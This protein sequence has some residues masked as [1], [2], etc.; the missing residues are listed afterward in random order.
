MNE[1]S[2]PSNYLDLSEWICGWNGLVWC[3]GWRK[4]GVGK[5]R[6]GKRKMWEMSGEWH[7]PCKVK[8]ECQGQGECLIS[9]TST[10]SLFKKNNSHESSGPKHDQ[11][12]TFLTY[13]QVLERRVRIWKSKGE[14]GGWKVI[15]GC[16]GRKGAKKYFWETEKRVSENGRELSDGEVDFGER[17]DAGIVWKKGNVTYQMVVKMAA[18]KWNC[19]ECFPLSWPWRCGCINV[20]VETTGSDGVVSGGVGWYRNLMDDGGR[21]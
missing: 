19:G 15:F 18:E 4:K 2:F 5:S 9:V 14:K 20:A 7:N 16:V 13:Y 1:Y 8:E 11:E 17:V 6:I 10:L 3:V 21:G 12:D